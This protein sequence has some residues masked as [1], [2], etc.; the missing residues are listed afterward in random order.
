MIPDGVKRT[1]CD[2]GHGV[3]SRGVRDKGWRYKKKGVVNSRRF[4]NKECK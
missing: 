3:G 2:F 1:P 4:L